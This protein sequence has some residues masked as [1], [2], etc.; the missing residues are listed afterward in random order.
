M[1]DLVYEVAEDEPVA[2][3]RGCDRKALRALRAYAAHCDN[4]TQRA[5][6]LQMIAEFEA[7]SRTHP[8]T[9]PIPGLYERVRVEPEPEPEPEPPKRFAVA[10]VLVDSAG[11]EFCLRGDPQ[12]YNSRAAARASRFAGGRKPEKRVVYFEQG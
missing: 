9:E 10:W 11:T 3:F 8:V 7:Y 12:L 4:E 5:A 1:D 2:L 6:L